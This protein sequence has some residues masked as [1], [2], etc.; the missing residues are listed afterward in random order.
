MG[1]Q[2]IAAFT[3]VALAVCFLAY[4]V[5]PRSQRPDVKVSSLVRKKKKKKPT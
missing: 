5:W 3:V 2:D 1:W 4:K